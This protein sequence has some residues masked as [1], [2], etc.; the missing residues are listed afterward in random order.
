MSKQQEAAA[1]LMDN[2]LVAL[3]SQHNGGSCAQR[4]EIGRGSSTKT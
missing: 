1:V 3:L 2:R 4:I